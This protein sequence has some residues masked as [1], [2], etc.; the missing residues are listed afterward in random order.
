MTVTSEVTMADQAEDLN[1]LVGKR[2]ALRDKIKALNDAHKAAMKPYN[3]AADKF[4]AL[5]LA[6]IDELGVKTLATE[7]GTI[8]PLERWSASAEDMQKFRQY[9]IDM[10]EW[11][12]ADIKPNVTAT[13]EYL[14][15]NKML[16]P[17]VKTSVFRDLGLR[18]S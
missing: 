5:L 4:D 17:G 3:E 6:R 11:D 2:I 1:R 14:E 15:K 8:F 12:L 16:P 9:L 7:A 10:E 18:R 13:R